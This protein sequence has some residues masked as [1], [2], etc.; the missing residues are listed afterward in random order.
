MIIIWLGLCCARP[1]AQSSYVDDMED[2][3]TDTEGRRSKTN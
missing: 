1:I 3:Q 2:R